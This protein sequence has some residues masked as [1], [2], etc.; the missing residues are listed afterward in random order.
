MKIER[1]KK[2]VDK[3]V[4]ASLATGKI[5]SRD[6]EREKNEGERRRRAREER[7]GKK[8]LPLLLLRTRAC[9]RARGRGDVVRETVEIWG[10]KKEKREREGERERVKRER[11]KRERMKKYV[12]ML[13]WFHNL[14]IEKGGATIW[15]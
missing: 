11:M 5:S 12:G 10:E 7:R 3:N 1:M 14:D 8:N 9:R 2:D 13:T 4:V 6:R 15:T